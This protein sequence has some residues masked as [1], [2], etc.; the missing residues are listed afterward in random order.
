MARPEEKTKKAID[1]IKS[2]VPS[3]RG[4]LIY[5]K[6]DLSDI[7]SAQASAEEFLRR[8][9]NLHLLFNNNS[10]GYPEKVSKSKQG[11]ELQLRVNCLRTFAFTKP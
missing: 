10:V 11:Y 9:Q 5:L 2:A 3:S 7:P 4:E 6:L 8:E 1:S